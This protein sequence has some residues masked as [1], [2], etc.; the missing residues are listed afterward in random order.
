MA[1]RRKGKSAKWKVVCGKTVRG[2]FKKKTTAKKARARF[3]KRSSKA[4]RVV[5]R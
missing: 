5:R 1:K 3:A 2:R 4:C